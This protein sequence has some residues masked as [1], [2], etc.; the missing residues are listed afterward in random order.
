MNGN[1]KNEEDVIDLSVLL[2]VLLK[3]LPL[4][5]IMMVLGAAAAFSYTKYLVP[6]RYEATATVIIN[7]K[8]SDS[9]QYI[10]AGDLSSSKNL[11]ELY[12]IIITSDTVLDKIMNDM[13]DRTTY[14]ELKSVRVETISESQVVKISMTSTDPKHAKE[15][16]EKFV[17]YSKPVIMDKVDAAGSVKDLNDTVMSNNGNPVSPNKKKNTAIGAMAGF[18][19]AAAIVI[20]KEL[21]NNTLKTEA[22]VKNVLDIPLLGVVPMVDRKEFSK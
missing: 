21:L 3:N 4:L 5:I 7:N 14:A 12:S 2:G 16:V 11:A 1:Y 20:L 22:D 18:V 8:T 10:T 9:Q 15:I 13:G 17:K 19:L 6:E